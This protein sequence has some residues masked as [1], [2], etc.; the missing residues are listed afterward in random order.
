MTARA[1]VGRPSAGPREAAD[2]S[3]GRI[4]ANNLRSVVGRA[5]PRVRGMVREP[6]WLLFEILL[7]FLT[8]SLVRVRLPR[9]PG[10]RRS[11]SGSSSSAGR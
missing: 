8:T 4:V 5:F 9:A 6:S 2:W 11:T 3:R 1:F 7:P 10:A